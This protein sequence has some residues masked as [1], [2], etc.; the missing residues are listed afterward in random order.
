MFTAHAIFLFDNVQ[1]INKEQMAALE[2][3][4]SKVKVVEKPRL[5]K[6]QWWL[7]EGNHKELFIVLHSARPGIH[8]GKYFNKS[9]YFVFEG[10]SSEINDLTKLLK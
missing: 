3:P 6:L 4:I 5:I 10:V 2:K 8:K 7:V 9:F 1:A